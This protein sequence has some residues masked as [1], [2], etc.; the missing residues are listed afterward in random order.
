MQDTAGNKKKLLETTKERDLGILV[1][2]DL[3]P[4]EQCRVAASRAMSVIGMVG[5]H[6]KRL[7]KRD[8]L[9]LYMSLDQ[10]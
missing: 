7:S 3:K 5:R 4:V 10:K 8:F 9:L 2:H 6:F 1:N